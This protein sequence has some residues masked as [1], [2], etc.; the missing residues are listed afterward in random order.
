M[1]KTHRWLCLPPIALCGIDH[2]ATL[3]WQSA[4][5][6]QGNY[7]TALE[8]NPQFNWLLQQH[9]LA[10][11]AGVVA[12]IGVFSAAILWLPRRWASA[13]ALAITIGHTVGASSWIAVHL[14]FGYWAEL[15][16]C[17]VS[18]LLVVFAEERASRH[19]GQTPVEVPVPVPNRGRAG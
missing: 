12:W 5:Y 6:W 3:W 7:A 13:S 19:R 17:V 18:A 4:A 1:H 9:P 15:A 10:F 2:G 8:M 16:L 11:E 14:T